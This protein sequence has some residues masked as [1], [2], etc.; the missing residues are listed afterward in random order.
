MEIL[1]P[2]NPQDKKWIAKSGNN[3]Q[4]KF[5]N[6]PGGEYRIFEKKSS[7]GYALSQKEV[8]KFK[9][10]HGK[11]YYIDGQKDNNTKIEL[12]VNKEIEN[13]TEDNPILV[14]NKKAEYP[15]TGGPGVWIGF[16][17]LGL[18]LMFIAV[19]TYSKRRDKLVL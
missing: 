12:I 1:D 2:T 8:F 6:I 7:Q 16:T 19:L 15:H 13:N 9:V 5:E 10:E 18:I 3:G 11:I 14:T 4:F 17:I